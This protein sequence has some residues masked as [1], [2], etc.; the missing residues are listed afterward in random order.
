[1][2]VVHPTAVVTRLARSALTIIGMASDMLRGQRGRKQ[3]TERL[4][5]LKALSILIEIIGSP[6]FG[7]VPQVRCR[8]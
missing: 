1:M 2:T 5:V 8:R 6:I 4:Q 3:L 7:A